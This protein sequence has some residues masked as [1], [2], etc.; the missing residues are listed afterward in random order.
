MEN[1]SAEQSR[2]QGQQVSAQLAPPP[3]AARL[4]EFAA[5]NH[6]TRGKGEAPEPFDVELEAP[7][8]RTQAPQSKGPRNPAVSSTSTE[9]ASPTAFST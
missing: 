7:A 9:P 2:E 4:A 1:R 8:H 5:T 6:Q 3:A